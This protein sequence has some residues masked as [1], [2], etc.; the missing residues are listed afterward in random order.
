MLASIPLRACSSAWEVPLKVEASA[1]AD[2]ITDR[3]RLESPGFCAIA[4]SEE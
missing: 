1:V 4:V 2:P 3:R